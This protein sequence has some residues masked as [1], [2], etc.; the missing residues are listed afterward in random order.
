VNIP[1][2]G[3]FRKGVIFVAL[4]KKAN[5]KMLFPKSPHLHEVYRTKIPKGYKN[6][7]VVGYAHFCEDSLGQYF[8]T[9]TYVHPKFR[10]QK[11]A[12]QIYKFASG[13]LKG[14]I[15]P[16]DLTAQGEKFW[17]SRTT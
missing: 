7:N 5:T 4:N 8:S 9:N 15:V 1:T 11:V 17:K 3:Y 12:S 6:E 16:G 10:R 14:K 13:K 2:L